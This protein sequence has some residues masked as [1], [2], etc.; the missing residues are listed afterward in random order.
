MWVRRGTVGAMET[1]YRVPREGEWLSKC[2]GQGSLMQVR[3]N[4][5]NALN[6]DHGTAG[7][8]TQ[9]KRRDPVT[10]P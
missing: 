4:R 5:Q 7:A 9:E 8:A 3:R 1:R 10:I 6:V 2:G